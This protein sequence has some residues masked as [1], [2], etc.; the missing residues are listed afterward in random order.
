MQ[1][2]EPTPVSSRSQSKATEKASNSKTIQIQENRISG[3]RGLVGNYP[4]DWQVVL[5]VKKYMPHKSWANKKLCFRDTII[6][7]KRSKKWWSHWPPCDEV[8]RQIM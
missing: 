7:E 6:R 1:V 3:R 4:L 8:L 5:M 2:Y